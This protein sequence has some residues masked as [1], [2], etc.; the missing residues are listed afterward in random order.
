MSIGIFGKKLGNTRVFNGEKSCHVSIIH[1]EPMDVISVR[2]EGQHT[3]M[4]VAYGDELKR[5]TKAVLGVFKKAKTNP[6]RNLAEFSVPESFAQ[7]YPV[8]SKL[9][10]AALSEV[11]CLDIS[12]KTKGAGF[13]GVVKRHG[14]SM[15]PATHGNSLS[16]RAH[17]S[18]GQ[19]QDPGRV[20]KGKRMAGQMGN[21]LRTIQNISVY[22]VDPEENLVW[23]LGAVPGPVGSYVKLTPSFKKK[24]HFTDVETENQSVSK[25][26]AA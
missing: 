19:C 1:A 16:H 3:M 15:Q 6:R 11:T 9:G 20:F 21:V 14:F 12:A 22:K 24:Q 5:T 10:V 4:Q 13:A 7:K 17:G 25:E 2:Q 23:V 26:E 8:G 18:T